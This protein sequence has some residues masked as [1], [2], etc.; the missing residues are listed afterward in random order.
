MR[1]SK[2]FSTVNWRRYLDVNENPRAQSF[3]E[4]RGDDVLWQIASNVHQAA[5]KKGLKEIVLLVHQNAGAVIKIP[6]TEYDEILYL[7]LKW[8]EKQENYQ[9]CAKIQWFI[10]DLEKLKKG[11]KPDIKH[12]ETIF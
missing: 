10:S 7:C 2:A 1:K 11:I 9:R 6:H 3:L 8:F 12:K 4:S 5:V